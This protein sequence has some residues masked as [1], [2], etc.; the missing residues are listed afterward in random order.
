MDATS[1]R[2]S[3]PPLVGRAPALCK[4]AEL[5]SMTGDAIMSGHLIGYEWQ[6]WGPVSTSVSNLA[7]IWHTVVVKLRSGRGFGGESG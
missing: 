7:H 2:P 3:P 4:T 5:W 1:L 6:C